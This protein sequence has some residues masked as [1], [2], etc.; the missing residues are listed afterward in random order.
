MPGFLA[1]IRGRWLR[2]G[3]LGDRSLEDVA[4]Q[5][6]ADRARGGGA[7]ATPRRRRRRRAASSGRQNS[8][9]RGGTIAAPPLAPSFRC[10]R[11]AFNPDGG[12]CSSLQ[13]T[14]PGHGSLLVEP[15]FQVRR[16]SAACW[17]A[18]DRVQ[19]PTE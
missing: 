4:L 14:P 9:G 3:I 12:A 13:R 11:C 16:C 10:A 5:R 7:R 15:V 1:S 18:L 2:I 8:A 6:L 17:F 19:V